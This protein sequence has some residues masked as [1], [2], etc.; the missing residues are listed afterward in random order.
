NKTY[1]RGRLPGAGTFPGRRGCA[2][3]AGCRGVRGRGNLRTCGVFVLASSFLYRTC[4][5]RHSLPSKARHG[6]LSQAVAQPRA[7]RKSP[8]GSTTRGSRVET[9]PRIQCQTLRKSRR[10]AN[11]AASVQAVHGARTV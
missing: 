10:L 7:R 3:V 8:R 4:R 9:R 6:K 1:A 11:F 2:E 5:Q